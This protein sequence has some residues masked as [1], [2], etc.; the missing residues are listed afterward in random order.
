[1]LNLGINVVAVN[2]YIIELDFR[3]ISIHEIRGLAPIL[4]VPGVLSTTVGTKCRSP[5]RASLP[6]TI[7]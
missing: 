4:S 7:A 2:N 3:I 1:M 6:R 5:A